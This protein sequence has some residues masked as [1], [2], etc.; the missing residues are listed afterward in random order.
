MPWGQLYSSIGEVLQENRQRLKWSVEHL[1]GLLSVSVEALEEIE[2]GHADL[3]YWG[4]VLGSFAVALR[5]PTRTL[6][7]ARGERGKQFQFASETATGELILRKRTA[8]GI[9]MADMATKCQLTEKELSAVEAGTS[10]LEHWSK[11]LLHM[12]ELFD[13]RVYDLLYPGHRIE[14]PTLAAI[15]KARAQFAASGEQLA[16]AGGGTRVAL[17]QAE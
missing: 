2:R 15:A 8:A 11:L 7:A 13:Q 16:A 9:A 14:R 6:V 1:A 12:A 17:G 3:E 10:G 5:V 4:S